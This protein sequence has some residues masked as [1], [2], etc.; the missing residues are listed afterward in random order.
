MNS[1]TKSIFVTVVA[2]I[3]IILSGFSSLIAILQSIMVNIMFGKEEFQ[4]APK[5]MDAFEKFM[6]ENFDLF[7]YGFALVSILTLISSIGLLKRLNWAR[8]FFIFIL[9]IGIIWQFSS[10]AWMWYIFSDTGSRI[11]HQPDETFKTFQI[12]MIG[13]TIALSL[14]TAL[15]FAWIIKK[16]T[17]SPIKEEFTLTNILEP[18][19]GRAD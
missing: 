16:L 2:W 5:N 19:A 6:I 11:Q 3:F 18:N 14:G 12:I 9:G 7:I 4:T 15:L 13:F 17:T 10:L 1:K 8:L